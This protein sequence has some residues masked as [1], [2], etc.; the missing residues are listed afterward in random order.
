[1]KFT[2]VV[3]SNVL[4]VAVKGVYSLLNKRKYVLYYATAY[5]I[6]YHKCHL[7]GTI[8]FLFEARYFTISLFGPV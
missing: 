2:H 3:L 6:I 5:S 4:S 1:M 8:L 7:T